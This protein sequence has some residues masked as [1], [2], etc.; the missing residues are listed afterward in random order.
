MTHG[1]PDRPRKEEAQHERDDGETAAEGDAGQGRVVAR[2]LD[3]ERHDR[4]NCEGARGRA[5]H[6][7]EAGPRP[8]FAPATRA[9]RPRPR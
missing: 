7:R 1:R 5:E 6:V 3:D 8:T 2:H 9:G 4:D